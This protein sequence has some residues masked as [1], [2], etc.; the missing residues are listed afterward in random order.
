MARLVNAGTDLAELSANT[1]ATA[2][3]A[4]SASTA[5][6]VMLFTVVPALAAA[7]A[8]CAAVAVVVAVDAVA[9]AVAALVTAADPPIVGT[10][11]RIGIEL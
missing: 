3:D 9:V 4:P 2:L 8:C 10:L 11:G 5:L 1:F 7:L 6:T